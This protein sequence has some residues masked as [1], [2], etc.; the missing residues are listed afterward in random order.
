MK[1]LFLPKFALLGIV[2][3]LSGCATNGD[4]RDPLEPLNRG[5]YQFNDTV[6]KAVMK[7]VA[8]GYKA[9]L[10]NPV[11]TGVGNFFSNIDDALIA[12]NNLLQFKFSQAA[13]DVARLI[14]NTTFGIGGLFDVATSFGLEKHNE[15][16]GQTLG[17]WGIGDGPFLMLPLLGPSNVRDTVG[18]VAYYK[19]DPVLNLNHIPTRNTLGAL[20]VID[21]RAR[22]LDAEKVLDEAALD[23]YTFL[24]DAYIQQRRSLIYDGNPP[25]EQLEDEPAPVKKAEAAEGSL[26]SSGAPTGVPL[27]GTEEVKPQTVSEAPVMDASEKK[28]EAAA[29]AAPSAENK[30]E[31]TANAETQSNE[32]PTLLAWLFRGGDAAGWQE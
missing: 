31:A 27:A 1:I 20:R 17:Y 25:R 15:D 11:R 28:L 3:A 21:R 5:I 4:P 16:F 12:V 2:I 10:P 14:A 30:A 7:P 19:L 23:P 9:V 29:P 22:L 32:M 26:H 18:L 13:S 6:D 8:Q 24:R